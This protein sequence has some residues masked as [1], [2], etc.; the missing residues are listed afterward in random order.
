MEDEDVVEMPLVHAVRV[1]VVH[2]VPQ[3]LVPHRAQ[4]WIRCNVHL[5]LLPLHLGQSWI[6][7]KH[8]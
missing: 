1:L 3:L 8:G 6:H 4:H 5:Q 2:A 7:L